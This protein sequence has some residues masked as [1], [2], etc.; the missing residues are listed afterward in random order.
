M[1]YN[2]TVLN[3]KEFEDL[4]KDLLETDLNIKLQSFKKGKDKGI[5]FRSSKTKENEIVIQV[6]HYINSKFSDL[7]YHL[8][9]TEKPKLLKLD[10]IPNRYII[11]TSL[12]LNVSETNIL[13]SNLQPYINSTDDIYG[14]KR[15]EDLIANNNIIEEKFYKLW[16]TSTNVLNRILHNGIK[17]KSEFYKEKILKKIGLYVKTDDY[18]KAIEKIIEHH[19]LIISGAPGIGKTSTAFILIC[20]FLAKGFELIYIDDKLK[21]AEDLISPDKKK[22]Q[23]F[24]FDDFLGSNLLEISNPRNSESSIVSFIE[25]LQHMKNKYLILTTRTTILNNANLVYEKFRRNSLGSISKYEVEMS[26]YSKLAKAKIL[27]N[28]LYQSNLPEELYEVYISKK[29]YLKVIEHKNYSPRLIE[30]ISQM[31]NFRNISSANF[32]NFIFKSLENPDQI[33]LDAYERQLEDEDRFLLTTLFSLGG[34]NVSNEELEIAFDSR[35]NYE[36]QYNNLQRKVNAFNNSLRKLLDGFI[37]SSIYEDS[38]IQT[39]SFLNPSVGDFLL[40]YLKNSP[41]ERKRILESVCLTDQLFNF[42]HPDNKNFIKLNKTELKQYFPIFQ[43]LSHNIHTLGIE[44]TSIEICYVH[45]FYFKSLVSDELILSFLNKIVTEHN[46]QNQFPRLFYIIKNS[47]QP[48]SKNF[49]TIN[50][51]FFICRLFD[52]TSSEDEIRDVV[53][54]FHIHNKK[55][56]D[57]WNDETNAEILIN[58]LNNVFVDLSKDYD[59]SDVKLY[60][61]YGGYSGAQDEINEKLWEIYYQLLSDCGLDEL[62]EVFSENIEFMDSEIYDDLINSQEGDYDYYNDNRGQSGELPVDVNNEIDRLFDR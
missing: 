51:D 33:W 55:I 4:C 34:Y 16:L 44:S 38:R 25:R 40:N 61:R 27:Y 31:R 22:K 59:F 15:L 30:F 43:N 5:D 52:T 1:Q 24:F 28:H 12:D 10:P 32:E 26:S 6:K 8:I 54:L 29:N 2:F 56:E 11:A 50:W 19:F 14:K 35:Y 46:T 49:I 37:V 45:L 41:F 42:F 20:D 53:T 47:D 58:S 62:P 17:G 7:K 48:K 3:D 57:F 9:K 39:F 13:F 21:D 23:I 18:H 36:I 60:D